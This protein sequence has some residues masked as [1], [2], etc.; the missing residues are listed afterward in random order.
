MKYLKLY[1]KF[2]E[3]GGDGGSAGAATSGSGDGGGVAYANASISGM[4]PV[5]S[6]Q[7]GLLPGTT[8]TV[9]SGDIGVVLR[10][11]KR[12]KGKPSEVSDLRDLDKADIVNIK[13]SNDLDEYSNNI[14]QDCLMELYDD[15]FELRQ[16]ENYKR[17]H[18]YDKDEDEVGEFTD[19]RLII[20]L[21]KSIDD[22]WSGNL[23]I[24]SKFDKNSVIDTNITTL[25]P[26]GKKLSK[27]E[28]SYLEECFNIS[29]KLI[30]LLDYQSGEFT[31]D[32]TK[33]ETRTYSNTIYGTNKIY[34]NLDIH[35]SLS[36]I[37]LNEKR[38]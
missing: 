36:N 27:Q 11:N 19:E 10:K 4:G 37:I 30:N 18:Q 14:I 26:R 38:D 1:K 35:F 6:A 9:G 5:V 8:G 24:K 32:I 12:K 28:N 7:P 15:G 25:R 33:R 17:V 16:L 21:S 20:S 22:I 3:D 2:F 31:I 34:N 29:N 13:E 23:K